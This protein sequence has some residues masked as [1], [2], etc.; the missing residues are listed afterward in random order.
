[1][2]L[3]Q[4]LGRRCISAARGPRG[5]LCRGS[6]AVVNPGLTRPGGGPGK[7]ELMQRCWRLL[8]LFGY[9]L[10]SSCVSA[11]PAAAFTLAGIKIYIL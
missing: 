10:E 11:S 2:S 9:K 7:T 8:S 3:G 6:D 1:M 4:G 5:K